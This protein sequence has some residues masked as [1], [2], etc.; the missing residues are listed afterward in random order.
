MTL[1]IGA[2]SPM[3][4]P[5]FQVLQSLTGTASGLQTQL[6]ALLQTTERWQPVHAD[7]ATQT[8]PA[9]PPPHVDAAAG[10]SPVHRASAARL[11][12]RPLQAAVLPPQPHKPSQSF[13]QASL[14]IVGSAKNQ[15]P[16]QRGSVRK[17][18]TRS[19]GLHTVDGGQAATCKETVP[20]HA[21]PARGSGA[22]FSRKRKAGLAHVAPAPPT[23]PLRSSQR[24][25][26][27]FDSLFGSLDGSR[28]T[29]GGNHSAPTRTAK[30]VAQA[31]RAGHA[32]VRGA[33]TAVTACDG[34]KT[35]IDDDLAAEIAAKMRRH[36]AKMM[37]QKGVEE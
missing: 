25:E 31:A 14:A 6:E 26:S 2:A 13:R 18:A 19:R 32:A 12:A 20:S 27:L 1:I 10:T 30:P 29:E 34:A 16:A 8:S 35:T 7:M 4:L 36:R 15:A 11:P 37:R 3:A 22:S 5:I 21:R 9:V 28:D 33:G 23:E 24:A 17:P